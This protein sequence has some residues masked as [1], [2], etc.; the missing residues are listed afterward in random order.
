LAETQST[1]LLLVVEAQGVQ[2]LLVVQQQL[3]DKIL[4]FLPLRQQA[5]A[6]AQE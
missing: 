2:V 4:Y 5:V 3:L 6:L 1:Q